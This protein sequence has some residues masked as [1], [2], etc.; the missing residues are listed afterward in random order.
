VI[1]DNSLDHSVP[2]VNEDQPQSALDT[3]DVARLYAALMWGAIPVKADKRPAL[4]SWKEFQT[5]RASQE[6]L[7]TWF[8]PH[9]IAIVTGAISDL[10][11]I[12]C[13][14]PEAVDLV[15]RLLPEGFQ[16]PTA[17]TPRGL[18]FYFKQGA[19]QVKNAVNILPGVDVRGEG[20]Y[21]V[22]PP[23]PGRRWLTRP[24]QCPLAELPQALAGLLTNR[25]SEPLPL[26]ATAPSQGAPYGQAALANELANLAQTPQGQRNDALNAS[27]FRLGQLV[28]GGQLAAPQVEAALMAIAA[29][30]GLGHGEAGKTIASGLRAGQM[31]PRTPETA[32]FC[33]TAPPSWPDPVPFDSCQ[34]PPLPLDPLPGWARD[35]VLAVDEHTQTPAC[36]VMAN[37]LGA[38]S[39]AIARKFVVRVKADYHE[40]LNLYI[41]TT[42]PPAERKTAVQGLCFK[43]LST[44]EAEQAQAMAP[45]IKRAQS[46]RKSQEALIA[47][48]RHKLGKAKPEE[49]QDL[50]AEIDELELGLIEAPTPPRLLADDITPEALALR[51]AQNDERL[52]IASTE[53]GLFDT[54][55]GRY[56]GMPNLDLVLKAHAGEPMR[57]DRKNG[58]PISL[59]NPALT[60][61][62][63]TQPEVLTGLA[64]K[65]GFRGR[66]LLGRFAFVMPKSRLGHRAVD[67]RP[68]PPA[69][70]LAYEQAMRALLELPWAGRDDNGGPQAYVLRLSPGASAAWLEFCQSLEPSLEP[71]LGQM[72]FIS[73][74]CGKLTGLAARLAGLIHVM[75]HLAQAPDLAIS[76]QTMER[77]LTLAAVLL[78]HAKAAFGLMGADPE[79]E[80]ARPC[81]NWLRRERPERF[82][83]R[84]CHRAVAGRLPKVDQVRKALGILDERG[85][86]RP[87]Q[88]SQVNGP[89]RPSSLFYRVNPKVVEAA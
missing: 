42:A 2:V 68:I 35:Y 73:D 62:I 26:P 15:K 3:F 18:H 41:L 31:E 78:E 72:A 48:L 81:L 16:T 12:D 82:S 11:V 76:P 45:E 39:T 85:Y 53:G 6:E 32:A 67:T 55:A 54:L 63:C 50:L 14:S 51:M 47:G 88:A 8:G 20:G 87:E 22:A 60:L 36:M 1:P 66:G 65:P 23:G 46:Q 9:Q 28:A 27:A 86:V 79:V 80:A 43:P 21:V 57:V 4:A 17:T 89:G 38:A 58:Q 19:Q 71:Q 44:W 61:C 64:G 33:E 5:R 29:S 74:W 7:Q 30:L 84:D 10:L 24:D 49:R 40:P 69:V 70:R 77:A 34:A 83:V 75:E 13:D 59:T 56:S 37:V 52:G 25:A